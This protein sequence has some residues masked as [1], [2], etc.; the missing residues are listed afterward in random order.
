[1]KT[2]NEWDEIYYSENRV[3]MKNYVKKQEFGLKSM[4][5]IFMDHTGMGI[6][7]RMWIDCTPKYIIAAMCKS[8]EAKYVLIVDDNEKKHLWYV[9]GD[10]YDKQYP[11]EIWD[12]IQNDI[13]D[14]VMRHYRN[15]GK[16]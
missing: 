6:V 15:G 5:L 1:M 12:K 13:S 4:N 14:D 10:V 9:L 16:L 2:L 7:K 3:D 8:L 11:D